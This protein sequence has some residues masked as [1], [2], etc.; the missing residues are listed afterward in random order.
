MRGV[1]FVEHTPGGTLAARL[2][3]TLIRVEHILGYRIKIVERAGTPLARKFPLSK[4]GEGAKCGRENCTTCEQGGGGE[5]LPPCRKRSV[6]YENICVLC[7]PQARDGKPVKTTQS[8]VPSIYV[9]ESSRS[10]ME[11]GLNHWKDFKAGKEDSHILKHHIL[12]HGGTGQPVF[13]LRPVSYHRTALDRQVAEA[14][15]IRRRGEGC[16]LNS[17]MEYNRCSIARLSLPEGPQ[18]QPPPVETDGTTT[19]LNAEREIERQK[20]EQAYGKVGTGKA[21][22]RKEE[23]EQKAAKKWKYEMVPEDWGKVPATG[24]TPG[25]PQQPPRAAPPTQT[26]LFHQHLH[27]TLPQAAQQARKAVEQTYWGTRQ[28]QAGT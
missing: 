20:L 17:K 13:H 25:S 16:V 10:L 12:H 5:K 28:F 2:R 8:D 21:E 6:L 1:L 11:R 26:W 27:Q 9:G 3:E 4:L 18:P 14:V 22:K 15:R 24:T 19:I 23:M 7:N